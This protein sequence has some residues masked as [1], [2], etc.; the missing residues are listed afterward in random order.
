[1]ARKVA[2]SVNKRTRAVEKRPVPPAA[3][4]QD[5]LPNPEPIRLAA[6][7]KK[8]GNGHAAEPMNVALIPPSLV[9]LDLA[10][11]QSPKEGFEGVDFFAPN[12]KHKVDLCKFPWPWKDA[13][14]DEIHTSHFIEHIPDREVSL[15]D[16]TNPCPC[17]RKCHG[18]HGPHQRD[19]CI[20]CA[21]F[22]PHAGKD[23]LFAFFD[24]CYRI[25]KPGGVVNV[26]CPSVRSERAFQDPTHRRFIAQATFFYLSAQWRK[27]NKLDHY[28]V[29][30]DFSGN[31]NFSFPMEYQ[32]RAD[33]VRNELF[34]HAW[35][36]LL[37]WTVVLKAIK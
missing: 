1:M 3:T 28:N 20:D 30:C 6:G 4:T 17:A 27:D 33:E 2:L 29:R 16:T 37:D 14:V 23:M 24:E 31:V 18:L 12:A 5:E 13:S 8:A 19:S 32:G 9:R 22:H 35:N 34:A 25:I 11:G 7:V 21:S 10:C 26:I 15:W 36:V